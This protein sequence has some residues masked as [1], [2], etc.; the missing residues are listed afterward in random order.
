MGDTLSELID[1]SPAAFR[2][3]WEETLSLRRSF[4]NDVVQS[5]LNMVQY[6]SFCHNDI[7]PPNIAMR[8]ESF[9]LIDFDMCSNKIRSD[10]L[11]GR[12]LGGLS[13][14]ENEARMMFTAAQIA[15][16]IFEAS[17]QCTV[18]DIDAVWEAWILAPGMACEDMP[19]S[20]PASFQSWVDS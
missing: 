12:V 13:G 20:V 18:N 7:R 15:L 17:Q 16:V 14:T 19:A 2:K 3:H 1:A 11:G 6:F 10:C 5:A 4:R 9:C 8:G